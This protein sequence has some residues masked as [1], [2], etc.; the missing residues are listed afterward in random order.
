M[1]ENIKTKIEDVLFFIFYIALFVFQALPSFAVVF[2]EPV[3]TIFWIACTVGIIAL[4]V[5]QIKFPCFATRMWSCGM[6]A[7]TVATI[8]MRSWY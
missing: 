4:V 2:V 8:M 6:V 1:T 7:F 3:S 5:Q